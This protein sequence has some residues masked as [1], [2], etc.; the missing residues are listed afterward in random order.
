MRTCA[1]AG[2]R[3]TRTFGTAR[4]RSKTP[5]ASEPSDD[6]VG[7][8]VER[9]ADG[10]RSDAVAPGHDLAR[11]VEARV[12]ALRAAGVVV[13]V[14]GVVVA[15]PLHAHGHAHLARQQRRLDDEVRLRLAAE[16]A[17]EERDVDRDLRLL[18]PQRLGHFLLRAL[19]VLRRRPDLAA[20]AVDARDRGRRLH[21]RLVEV[22]DVVLGG[23]HPRRRGQRRAR[24]R[25]CC[26]TPCRARGRTR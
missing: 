13:A 25:P 12:Q 6:A 17:A 15:R 16:A 3:S 21:R 2:Q 22:R 19:R 24:R 23:D 7:L 1:A 9:P 4:G 5:W 8:P 10:R 26:G 18:E 20:L 14:A 11:G